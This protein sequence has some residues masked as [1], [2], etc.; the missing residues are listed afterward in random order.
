MLGLNAAGGPWDSGLPVTLTPEGEQWGL[1]GT[2]ESLRP[3]SPNGLLVLAEDPAGYPA[4]WVKHYVAPDDFR[5]F[6]RVFDR[7]GE[8]NADDI[9][10]LA[11]YPDPVEPLFG[12][13]EREIADDIVAVF[14]YPWYGNP[15]TSGYWSHWNGPG[16]NP[17]STWSS[18]YAPDFPDSTWDPPVMLY[19]STDPGLLCWQD[20]G[21]ARAGVDIAI[22]SWWGIGTFEDNAL[23]SA[24]QSCKSVQWCI[25]YE[26][27]GFADPPVEQLVTDLRSVIDRFGPTRN[28]AKVDNKWLVFVY[29][30][31]DE[32]AAARWRTAKEQLRDAGYELYI[33]A[34][35][36][37]APGNF[38]D[39]WDAI[40]LYDLTTR[41]TLTD[42]IMVG[43]DSAALSPGF[44]G[45]YE[46]PQLERDLQAYCAA[47]ADIVSEA[48]RARFILIETWNEWHE[49]TSIEPGQRINNDVNGFTPTG[50][51]YSFD[52]VD[53]IAGQANALRWTTPGHRA[54]LPV[55]L[56]AERIVWE[57]GTGPE[58]DDAWRISA[59]G[60]RIGASVQLPL[61]PQANVRVSVR[62][63]AVQVGQQAGWPSLSLYWAGQQIATWYVTSTVYEH[64]MLPSDGVAA[65]EIALTNDPGGIGNVDLV[66]DYVDVTWPGG[67]GDFDGD[68]DVDFADFTAFAACLSGPEVPTPPAGCSPGEFSSRDLDHDYD[69]DLLDFALFQE[70]FGG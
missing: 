39:P 1:S 62:A 21:M 58:G 6:V 33:N 28:Y 64:L 26:M 7:Q 25:Y 57:P 53:A 67:L 9:R 27:E 69:V 11:V 51:D 32:D 66:I 5:G 59:D 35:G 19:D 54:D 2:W 45:A 42:T 17:P 30:A 65:V 44:W 29:I 8:P 61:A 41:Q 55:R 31:N 34:V 18:L 37:P 56:Q 60:A 38:P 46:D 49:G 24:I 22:G 36:S 3:A 10:R 4:A 16:D 15:A 50:D 63:R 23:A 52:F 68:G 20:Q 47:W 12:N 48:E 70:S 43:D 14:Y 40:H 13:N